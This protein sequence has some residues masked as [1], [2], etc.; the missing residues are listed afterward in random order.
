M[1]FKSSTIHCGSTLFVIPAKAGIP[2]SLSY[3][4]P[5]ESGV[6]AFAGVTKIGAG[7]HNVSNA[8]P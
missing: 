8:L 1:S 4:A 2:L 6:P 7:E 3:A 5:G